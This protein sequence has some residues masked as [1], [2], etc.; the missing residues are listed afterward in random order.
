MLRAASQPRLKP[1]TVSW[2]GNSAILG[3]RHWSLRGS[4]VPGRRS[5]DSSVYLPGRNLVLLSQA[6]AFCAAKHLPAAAIGILRGNPFP[7][8]KPA[9]LRSMERAIGAA[10]A[11]PFKVWAP[12]RSMTKREALNRVPAPGWL[13]HAFSCLAPVGGRPCGRCNKCA[14][15]DSVL[16]QLNGSDKAPAR[17]H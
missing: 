8:A 16:D 7:D 17:P 15:R 6:G 11:M 2:A 5:A 12:Y 1:L 10:Y 13:R 9:F 4:R 14:E 3:S